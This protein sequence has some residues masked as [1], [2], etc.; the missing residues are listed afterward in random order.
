VDMAGRFGVD[1]ASA[2][3]VDTAGEGATADVGGVAVAVFGA[4]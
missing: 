4:V 1:G 2:A 3:P